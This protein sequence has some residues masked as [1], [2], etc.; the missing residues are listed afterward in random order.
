MELPQK[1]RNKKGSKLKDQ[2]PGTV[3]S[4]PTR[5]P[6]F[7]LPTGFLQCHFPSSWPPPGSWGGSASGPPDNPGF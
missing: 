3:P 1:A 5:E 7:P 2:K 6:P 4:R